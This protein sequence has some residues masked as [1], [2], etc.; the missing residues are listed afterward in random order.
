MSQ[1]YETILVSAEDGVGRIVLNRPKVLNAINGLMVRE[2][3]EALGQLELDKSVRAIVLSA[4]GRA[5]C[6]GFDFKDFGEREY[7]DLSDRLSSLEVGFNFIM[8]FWDCRKPTIS[9]VHGYCLAG[10]MELALACDLTIASRDA[11]FGEPEVRFGG[12]ILVML[13]PWIVGPKHAKD[14]LLTGDDRIPAERAGAVGLVTEVV[15]EGLHITRALQKAR[16]I[17]SASPLSVALTKRAINRGFDIRGMRAALQAAADAEII[18]ET[19]GTPERK[20]FSRIQKER[21]LKD[22]IAW[23]DAR[24][25]S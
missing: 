9:A 7:D 1:Q 18:I 6:A 20:E 10:G 2:V 4:E 14:I 8:Q 21:G 15:D 11:M 19:S 12:S 17:A 25:R 13:V 24:Y 3:S 5:F 22:A 16:E 23:R